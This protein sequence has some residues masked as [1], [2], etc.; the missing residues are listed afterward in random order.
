MRTLVLIFATLFTFNAFAQSNHE[1]ENKTEILHK[2]TVSFPVIIVPQLFEKGWNDRT[3]TQHIEFHVKRNLDD[4]N[5]IGVK[6]ATWRLFQPM[7]ILWWDGLTDKVKSETE[8][9]P[10]HLRET[11]IGISYQRMLWKGLFATAEVLPQFKTYLNEEGKK[12]S[13]GFKLYNSFHIG[14]HLAFGRNKRWFVEPQIHSQFWVFDTNTP[15]D[16]KALDNKWKNYFLFEPNLYFGV[17]F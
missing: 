13:N 5:I 16:F 15:E 1:L 10:G 3:H 6:L 4:K 14:Y 12:I 7:G 2:Y 17:K 8:F 11:G 9:Y